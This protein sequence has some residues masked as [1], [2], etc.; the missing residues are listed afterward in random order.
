MTTVIDKPRCTTTVQL[1]ELSAGDVFR[2]KIGFAETQTFIAL[3]TKSD[4]ELF[5]LDPSTGFE[6]RFDDS[7][8]GNTTIREYE[9]IDM[10]II[11]K[12]R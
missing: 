3:R 7:L 8:S 12:N 9:S 6:N 2:G 5:R 1:K 10:E 11:L 4:I